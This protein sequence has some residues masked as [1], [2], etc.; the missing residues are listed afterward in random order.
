MVADQG[1]RPTLG[2]VAV[3]AGTAGAGLVPQPLGQWS[4]AHPAQPPSPRVNGF[5]GHSQA[6]GDGNG[7]FSLIQPQETLGPA[8]HPGV[9]A[10]TGHVL[11]FPTLAVGQTYVSHPFLPL[12]QVRSE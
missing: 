8:D 1:R 6:V 7:V 11:Q 9:P 4:I 3:P 5:S 12:N 2:L 10:T